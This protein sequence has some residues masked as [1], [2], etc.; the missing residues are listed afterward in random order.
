MRKPFVF[1]KKK[2]L[3]CCFVYLSLTQQQWINQ[4]RELGAGLSVSPTNRLKF[5]KPV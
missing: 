3:K 1:K 2:L 5:R 4:W